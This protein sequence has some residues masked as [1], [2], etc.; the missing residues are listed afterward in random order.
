MVRPAAP[1]RST[2]ISLANASIVSST[3]QRIVTGERLGP[4]LAQRN[5]EIGAASCRR[6]FQTRS[7]SVL[8]SQ[9]RPQARCRQSS[10][11]PRARRVR[12][13]LAVWLTQVDTL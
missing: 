8:G 1:P 2:G 7:G 6:D 5:A 3:P 9:I 12:G 10:R 4:N 13:V 11:F